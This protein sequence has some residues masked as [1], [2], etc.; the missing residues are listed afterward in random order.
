MGPGSP[1]GEAASD[2]VEY[3]KTDTSNWREN[4]AD[5]RWYD[6]SKMKQT[7]EDRLAGCIPNIT[8][9]EETVFPKGLGK[10][11]SER[12]DSGEG[13]RVSGI[14]PRVPP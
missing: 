14:G 8:Y 10:E 13:A 6:G 11:V 1:I 5:I 3:Y 12:N 4:F 7:Q 9:N 2:M